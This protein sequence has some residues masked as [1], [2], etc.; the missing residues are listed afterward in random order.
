MKKRVL[1]RVANKE[2]QVQQE[3]GQWTPRT[4]SRRSVLVNIFVCF[5]ILALAAPANLSAKGQKLKFRH[6]SIE[7]GLS[8]NSITSILQDSRGFMWI[9]T[10]DGL[11]KYDGY[12]FSVYKRAPDDPHSLSSNAIG[13]IYEDRTGTLWVG[14]QQ[15]G[16]LNRFDR[17]R[18]RWT[19]YHHDPQDPGSLS[20]NDVF[21]LY[22]D[23]TGV[24]WIGTADGLNAYD[25]KTDH[26]TRYRHDPQNPH[27]ISH[28]QIF[29]IDE[30][31]EGE[32][33]V[34]TAGGLNRFDRQ[35]DQFLHYRHDPE[36][37]HSLHDNNV[38]VIYED[39]AGVLWIG[40]RLGL[41]RFDRATG[42]FY[43][44]SSSNRTTAIFED[45]SGILW[46]GTHGGG[47]RAFNQA[48]EQFSLYLPDPKNPQSL[49]S[50]IITFIYEDRAGLLWVGTN[51][52]LNLYDPKT[53][54]FHHYA[55]DPEDA[56]SLSNNQVK[57]IYEEQGGLLWIGTYGGGLNAYDRAEDAFF[58][59]PLDPDN[60]GNVNQNIIY[61]IYED[62]I[63]MLWFGTAAG[64]YTFDPATGQP[65]RYQHD[66]TDPTSLNHNSVKVISEDQ[67]GTLWVGTADGLHTFDRNTEQFTRYRHDP[68]N[69]DSLS[70]GI[71]LSIF[72][73]RQGTLWIGTYGGGLNR[74]EPDRDGFV[75]FLSDP[76][77]PHSLSHNT[78]T[79]LHEDQTGILW[80]GTAGG[81]NAFD[82]SAHRF[83]H[84]TEKDGLPNDV[85]YGML[86]DAS[87]NLWIS[88]NKG[89]SK[90]NPKTARFRNYAVSDGLQSNEFN[91]GA[92]YK[93]QSGEMFFGGINGFNAFYPDQIEDNPHVPAV[94]LTD[95]QLFNTSVQPRDDKKALLHKTITETSALTLSYQDAVVSFEFAALHYAYPEKNRYAYILD[96]F[97]KQWNYIDANRRFVTYTNLP[98][99][100]FT[101][102]IKA[103]NSDGLWNEEGTALVITVTPPPWKT[104]WAYTL[105]SLA[106]I[107]S[108]LGY[109]RYKQKQFERKQEALRQQRDLLDALVKE[110]TVELNRRNQELVLINEAGDMF[111]STLD[112]DQVLATVLREICH[113]LNIR[114]ASFWVCIPETEELVCQQA[115]GQESDVVIGLRLAPGQGILGQAVQ[116]GEIINA[117]DA[118]TDP[119]HY[120]KVEQDTGIEYR[121]I[122][123]I[124]FQAKETVIGVLSLMDTEVNRFTENELRLVAP[125]TATAASAM[126]N[127]RLHM[128]TEEQKEEAEAANRKILESIR[129]A[130]M[131]QSSLLPNL[132]QSKEHFSGSFFL[133]MPRDIVGG[134]MYIVELFDDGVLIGVFDCTG[135]GVPGAFM[136]MIAS[137]GIRRIV[138]DE[139]C[140]D[141]AVILQRLSLF[142]KTTLRQD[143]DHAQS[144]DGLD[145]AICFVNRKDRSLT[146]A[147]AK[148]PLFIVQNG[149]VTML[150]GDKQSVGYKRSDVTFEFTNRTVEIL[151]ETIF[152]LTT[153]GFVDQKG[154]NKGFPLGN[155]RFKELLTQLS[156]YPFAQ[157]QENLLQTFK[158]HK[159]DYER[160]D[161]VTVV[162]FQIPD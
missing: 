35:H 46:V 34:G 30:D 43:P 142:V 157:Q 92:Y 3:C 21:A 17:D 154:G 7:H 103:S 60:S 57:A 140:H 78:V 58:Q 89:I 6:L 73:D 110:R 66:P 151:P 139:A 51:G 41:E 137:A 82:R 61:S 132:T 87:G 150:K 141:P 39:R 83:T 129:Y 24:L 131:I 49:S 133:W 33:W 126:E 94:V 146:F 156:G 74:F 75:H 91:G 120:R 134:D 153:D 121:S 42:R 20:N 136:T 109:V 122:L 62:Q 147:G 5:V 127:A 37:P 105:Y 56:D 130:K 8:Q 65:I 106:L 16:G 18:E 44:S 15:G 59:I 100:K 85:I 22:A 101:L 117:T 45:Q 27:S 71:V 13:T 28:N 155:R 98:P 152:Y 124:P 63:G 144:D 115:I 26:F 86:E 161:D 80:V 88:T 93:S 23:R 128:L 143:T 119:R 158:A 36:N 50:K 162:G 29:S 95:F 40:T 32:L 160:Q 64:L 123:G 25:S 79:T 2:S 81:L 69:P 112:W 135:H 47:L 55:H 52:G 102:R 4:N 114:A 149:D 31:Q 70:P 14:T 113:L 48:T 76:D 1:Y 125:I 99:G 68:D 104:W 67:A 10:L 11:N 38:Y 118:R 111:N 9:G 159:G 19:R 84:Y 54:Q 116:A 148:L 108:V 145:A 138:R 90:F 107:T 12:N 53:R 96:G 72:Q 97:E 77:D